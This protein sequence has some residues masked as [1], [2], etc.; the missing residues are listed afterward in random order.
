MNMI[1]LVFGTHSTQPLDLP[2]SLYEDAYQKA[3][4]PFLTAVYNFPELALT[5]HYS[6]PLLSWLERRHPE[7]I[8]RHPRDGGA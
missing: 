7:F 4:K 5:L 3:Y 1:K 6:G 2:E 8:N